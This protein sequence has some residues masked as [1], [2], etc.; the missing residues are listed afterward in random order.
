MTIAAGLFVQ[1]SDLSEGG[2]H[3]GGICAG[4]I[5]N[6]G[7][8]DFFTVQWSGRGQLYLNRGDGTFIDASASSGI[9]AVDRSMH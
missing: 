9:A 6:D 2:Y 5:D 8:L 3:R 1:P 7:D 4:D